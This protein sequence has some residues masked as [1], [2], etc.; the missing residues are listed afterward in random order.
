MQNAL[1]FTKSFI[2]WI[3]EYLLFLKL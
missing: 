2:R 1:N 3:Y